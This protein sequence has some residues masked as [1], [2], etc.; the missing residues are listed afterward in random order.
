MERDTEIHDGSWVEFGRWAVTD[1]SDQAGADDVYVKVRPSFSILSVTR[2]TRRNS[3]RRNSRHD[4]ELHNPFLSHISSTWPASSDPLQAACAPPSN[5]FP[6]LE[7]SS[8]SQTRD[9]AGTCTQQPK[10]WHREEA[11][12][13]RQ[14]QR[15]AARRVKR[16][17][18]LISLP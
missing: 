4:Q 18:K 7:Q 15:I 9:Y 6:P 11:Q 17:R 12:S 3:R 2:R 5:S 13:A 1:Q 14:K 8:D 10:P 16:T